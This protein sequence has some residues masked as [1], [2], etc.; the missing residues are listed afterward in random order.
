V[1]VADELNV[2]ASADDLIISTCIGSD[3]QLSTT[4]T[5]GEELGTGGY[6]YSWAP[7]T[8]LSA[9]DIANPVAKPSST[10]TYTVTVTDANGCTA[11]DQVTI[12]VRPEL[13]ATATASDYN[14]GTC[15]SSVSTLNV[16]VSGGEA[17]YTYQ[18]DNTGTLTPAS[19][20]IVNPTAKPPVTTTYT[21]TVTDA[22]GCQ[23]TASVTINVV[24]ELTVTA[25]VTDPLIGTC[26]TSVTQIIA[27]ASGG[28]A[29]Y[30][31]SWDNAGTLSP[32]GNIANPTAKPPR[33]TPTP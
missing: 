26:F 17:P 19:G 7:S 12:V 22:N 18:W 5:G 32:S 24:P 16:S 27:S 10:T 21:V 23:T 2:V 28:E 25:S 29:P 4:V 11:S 15:L 31:Y 6:T 9:T 1:E 14:T 13:T 33:H 30:S 8:G 3:A 20:D